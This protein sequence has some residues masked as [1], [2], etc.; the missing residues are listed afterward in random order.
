M[1]LIPSKLILDKKQNKQEKKLMSYVGMGSFCGTE[2]CEIAGIFLLRKM[3]KEFDKQIISDFTIVT[4]YYIR[5]TVM[6]DK[7]IM[8]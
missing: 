5:M 2:T 4:G 1:S 7:W 8:Q 3:T 6:I